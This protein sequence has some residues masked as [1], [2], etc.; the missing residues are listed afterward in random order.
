MSKKTTGFVGLGYVGLPEALHRS[1]K[2][3]ETI[4]GYDTDYDKVCRIN[5]H[6]N[7]FL[8]SY[9]DDLLTSGAHLKASAHPSI[10]EP[11]DHIV[12]AVPTPVTADKKP[13]YSLIEH[14]ST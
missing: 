10:L 8:D 2:T 4:V 1:L 3:D 13:D 12:I 6:E 14:A 7:P 9:I 11:A 5:N